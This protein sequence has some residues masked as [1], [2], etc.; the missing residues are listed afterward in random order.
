MA[1]TIFA[2]VEQHTHKNWI[3]IQ[4]SRIWD[5][6]VIGVKKEDSAP[7]FNCFQRREVIELRNTLNKW[8]M[9]T[10]TADTEGEL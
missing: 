5:C 2:H 4:R 3:K 8:I 6:L 7:I 10:H 9:E 1:K